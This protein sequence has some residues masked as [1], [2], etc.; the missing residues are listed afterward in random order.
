MTRRWGVTVVVVLLAVL[1]MPH[2]Q[3]TPHTEAPALPAPFAGW[4]VAV[5]Q[6]ADAHV[7]WVS[8]DSPLLARRVTMRVVLPDAY[9]GAAAALPVVYYLHGTIR[10]G[11]DPAIDGLADQLAAAGLDLGYPFG[12]GTAH[13]EAGWLAAEASRL[14]FVVVSPD[15]EVDDPWCEHCAWVNGLGGVGVAAESHLYD[16]VMPLAEAMYR[17]RSDRAGRGIMGASMGAGGAL[18]QATRHPDRFAVVAAL[19]PPID[20]LY[21]TPYADF[22]AFLY[23]REQGYPQSKLDPMATRAINAA[24]LLSTLRGENIDTIITV[25]EGCVAG[26]ASPECQ[27]TSA[28]DQPIDAFQEIFIRHNLDLVVPRAIAAGVPVS[29]ITYSGVHFIPNHEVFNRYLL[30][31]I[32][33]D[34]ATGAP[35]PVSVTYRSGDP[36]ISVWGYQM[37]ID[38]PNQEFVTVDLRTDGT[39]INVT[40]SGTMVLTTPAVF[41]PGSTHTVAVVPSDAARPESHGAVVADSAGRIHV[42]VNLGPTHL[43]D[44]QPAISALGLFGSPQTRIAILD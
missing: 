41:A 30:D 43:L 37:S 16:E 6:G 9:F 25:G 15:A 24:D 13:N 23:L 2:V 22:L 1:G 40:G 28:L 19:S 17:I 14:Q 26:A 18:A 34:F 31:R 20:Y 21:D 5:E 39:A 8:F 35:V 7:Q 12:S 42:T 32:N 38:R 10:I 36:Q 33:H 4:N 44:E 29:Y 27:Q 3:A 11:T